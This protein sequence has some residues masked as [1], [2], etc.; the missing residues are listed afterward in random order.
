MKSIKILSEKYRTL[1]SYYSEK[2]S[3]AVRGQI[4]AKLLPKNGVGA[5]LGVFKGQFSPYLFKNTNAFKLHLIDPWFF[6]Y[7]SVDLGNWE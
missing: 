4:M 3:N 1:R 6:S 2:K 5:E 7:R